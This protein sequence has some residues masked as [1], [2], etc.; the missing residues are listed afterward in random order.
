MNE[1]GRWDRVHR[2]GI[3]GLRE[4]PLAAGGS[5]R[6]EGMFGIETVARG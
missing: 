6:R 1:S 2:S 5:I 3:A 4:L